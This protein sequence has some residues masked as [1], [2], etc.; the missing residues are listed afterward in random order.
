MDSSTPKGEGAVAWVEAEPSTPQKR[1]SST[2]CEAESAQKEIPAKKAK[3]SMAY[4]RKVPAKLEGNQAIE[5]FIY[6]H[7]K[8]HLDNP[9][10]IRSKELARNILKAGKE[11]GVNVFEETHT[12]AGIRSY[13]LRHYEE[14]KQ[15]VAAMTAS[16]SR[17]GQ[18]RPA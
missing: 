8:P 17:D 6:D 15:K 13:I 2:A 3:I 7:V 4:R 16:S 18:H 1:P 14:M 10:M 9:F 11:D 12:E 5:S